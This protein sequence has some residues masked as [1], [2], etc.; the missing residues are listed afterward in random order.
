MIKFDKNGVC[1]F[2][3]NYKKQDF[4]GENK[5]EE[6][7]AQVRSNDGRVDCVVGLS[8]GRDSSYGL[9]MLKKSL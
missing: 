7:L 2:C 6:I 5:L 9:H 4:L 1:N 3:N 8:G